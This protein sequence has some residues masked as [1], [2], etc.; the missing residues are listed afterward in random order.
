MLPVDWLAAIDRFD[1][2]AIMRD[3]L[4]DEFVNLFVTVKRTEYSRFN[5]VVTSLDHHWYLQGA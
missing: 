2:S 4:G 1:R 3:Y 5:A